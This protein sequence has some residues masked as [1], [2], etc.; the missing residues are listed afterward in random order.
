MFYVSS[1]GL[2]LALDAAGLDYNTVKM[3]GIFFRDTAVHTMRVSCV[4]DFS[5]RTTTFI[6]GVMTQKRNDDDNDGGGGGS[7]AIGRLRPAH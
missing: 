7:T 3:S 1:A 4:V 5:G 2:G 6:I